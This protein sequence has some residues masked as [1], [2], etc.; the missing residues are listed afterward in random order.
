MEATAEGARPLG[1]AYVD[2]VGADGPAAAEPALRRE[3]DGQVGIGP[4]GR[5]VDGDGLEAAQQRQT[6]HGRHGLRTARHVEPCWSRPTR[7]I[8]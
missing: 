7:S 2:A 8:S 5:G 4:E 1:V 3:V 6:A